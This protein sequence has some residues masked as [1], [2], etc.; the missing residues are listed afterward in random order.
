MDFTFW[1]QRLPLCCLLPGHPFCIR[2]IT[3]MMQ[4]VIFQWARHCSMGKCLTA[5]CLIKGNVFVF[6]L[7]IVLFRI[8]YNIS[9]CIPDGGVICI[10]RSLWDILCFMPVYQ[11]EYSSCSDTGCACGLFLLLQLLLR[12]IGRGVMLSLSDMGL[13]SGFAIF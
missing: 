7:W 2:V 12:R 13:V 10:C 3:G 11:E 4:T 6:L 8:A 5:M 1:Q 9:G